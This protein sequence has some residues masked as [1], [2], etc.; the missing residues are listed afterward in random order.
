VIACAGSGKTTTLLKRVVDI[1]KRGAKAEET[2][3]ITFTVKAAEELRLR[4]AKSLS[5]KQ[6][7][8]ELYIGTIHGFCRHLLTQYCPEKYETLEI[9]SEVQQLALLS[10]KRKEWNLPDIA[11]PLFTTS[12]GAF[13]RALQATIN[14]IKQERLDPAELMKRYPELI[15][16][17][18]LYTAHLRDNNLADYND[19]LLLTLDLFSTSTEFRTAI[20]T[21]AK[22]LFVD[23]YQDVDPVQHEL[24]LKISDDQKL[25]IIGDDDQAIYQFRG[26]DYRNFLSLLKPAKG[27]EAYILET[28]YRCRTHIVE[29]GKRIVEKITSRSDKPMK[30]DKGGGLVVKQQFE[31]VGDEAQFVASE[32]QRLKSSGEILRYADA[33]ILLRSVASHSLH[34]I[35]ALQ[36]LGIPFRT[37]GDGSLFEDPSVKLVT[38]AIEFIAQPDTGIQHL[39]LISDLLSLVPPKNVMDWTELSD[40]DFLTAGCTKEQVRVFRAWEAVRGRYQARKFSSL[41]ELVLDVIASLRV[42]DQGLDRDASNL[43]T[44]TQIVQE[45]DLT[46]QTKNLQFLCGFF[47]M[48]SDRIADQNFLEDGADGVEILTVH[49]AKGLQFSAVFLPM[50]CEGR[51]PAEGDEQK[52]LI[53]SAE[54]D[55][56]RYLGTIDDERRLFYVAV[57]R[58]ADR[59]Y[60]S[61][62]KD[63][64]LKRPK[65]ASIFFLEL[66]DSTTG[67]ATQSVNSIPATELPLTTSYSSLEL[68]LS[69]PYRF[70]LA[71]V[72]A[73]STPPNPFYEFGRTLHQVLRHIHTQHKQGNPVPPGDVD[74]IYDNYFTLRLYVPKVTIMRRRAAGI[75]AIKQY[76][77]NRKDWLDETLATE[78]DFSLPR[79]KTILRGRLDLLLGTEKKCSIVDFKTGS[80]HDY[81]DTLFQIGLYAA[82]GR[83]HFGWGIQSCMVYYIE[84]DKIVS[85]D[86]G[87]QLITDTLQKFDA[88]VQGIRN[89]QF[90]PTPGPVCTRCEYRKM[91]PHVL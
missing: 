78:R 3:I 27:R 83:E 81:I 72:L 82:V 22:W 77:V 30:S 64:G 48:H 5:D 38:A 14:I 40:N 2:T 8:S 24:V 74:G 58:A 6:T 39:S 41:L 13:F 28:N 67:T 73:I 15:H 53:R 26:T 31:T 36:S 66:H 62:A 23:E 60:A 76:L 75:A 84:H 70:K 20:R 44:L 46:A 42:L 49:Q 29:N 12:K 9:L 32:I 63:V 7:I 25:C 55:S 43:G 88:V 4:L 59:L 90:D 52:L 85:Y 33:A 57:T 50:L 89:R 68:Y 65:A 34:Y 18:E 16:A 79:G 87:D 17:Y 91:C 10:T 11:P 37:R 61:Y 19:L 1:L 56:Q 35:N 86:V 71:K 80:P 51:F 45:F 47:A 54:F 69:C 21:R